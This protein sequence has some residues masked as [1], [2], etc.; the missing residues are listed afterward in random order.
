MFRN[1][2]I[3]SFVLPHQLGARKKLRS[4]LAALPFGDWLVLYL[5]ARNIDR[6]EQ[7]VTAL[8]SKIH[9]SFGSLNF[10]VADP[11]LFDS[12]LDR[13]SNP[14]KI[15]GNK[16]IQKLAQHTRVKN[17]LTQNFLLL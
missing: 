13:D 11:K 3:C 5:V 16:I 15:K 8:Q 6:S 17:N 7:T 14:G 9:Y 2:F 12:D 10:S 4:V 1:G